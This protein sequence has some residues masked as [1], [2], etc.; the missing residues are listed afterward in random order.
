MKA[1]TEVL[2]LWL[3]KTRITI[4][5]AAAAA[6]LF[7]HLGY[8]QQAASCASPAFEARLTAAVAQ[9]EAKLK[10][11]PIDKTQE[12]ARCYARTACATLTKIEFEMYALSAMTSYSADSKLEA[13][14][15]NRM[16][17]HRSEN[18]SGGDKLPPK[19]LEATCKR[20]LNIR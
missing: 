12:Y 7:P 15:M 19:T 14:Y 6:I 4:V 1:L 13:E 8:P 11:I 5:A 20:E 16:R 9:G 17:Q 18:N 10:S 3:M 2:Y